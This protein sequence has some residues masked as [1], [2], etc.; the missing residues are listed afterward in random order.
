MNLRFVNQTHKG[1]ALIDL[2]KVENNIFCWVLV[3]ESDERAR[4]LVKLGACT[5]FILPIDASHVD[6]NVNQLRA[7]LVVL[8]VNGCGVRRDVDFAD[9]I[10]KKGFLNIGSSDESVHQWRNKWNLRQKF[11]H[12]FAESFVDSVVVDTRKLVGESALSLVVRQEALHIWLDLVKAISL[13]VVGHE[14]IRVYFV[15]KYFVI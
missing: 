9:N 10:E 7:N 15:D 5:I 14:H 11:L 8:H 13:L 4:L 3:A 6:E 2:S 1:K 12:D